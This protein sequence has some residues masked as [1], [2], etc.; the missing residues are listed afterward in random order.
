MFLSKLVS[1]LGT[2]GALPVATTA[3]VTAL[4]A[5]SPTVFATQ[6]TSAEICLEMLD[7]SGKA[8]T[9]ASEKLVQAMQDFGFR[10]Q[11]ALCDSTPNQSCVTSAF[12]L[13]SAFSLARE[14]AAK[15][16]LKQMNAGLALGGT[17]E[18]DI[19]AAYTSLTQAILSPS[20]GN[21]LTFANALFA[22]SD[23]KVLKTFQQVLKKFYAADAENL[24]FTH[25]PD[26]ATEHINRYVADATNKQIPELFERPL[27]ADTSTVLVNAGYFKGG[28]A[29]AFDPQNTVET[30]SFN[31]GKSQKLE[32][33]MMF[34]HGE[35]FGYLQGD[36][37]QMVSLSY[38]NGDFAMDLIVP[39]LT[40]RQDPVESL[41]RVQK[42]LTG[43][44]YRTWVGSLRPQELAQ[45]GLPRFEVEINLD[46]TQQFQRTFPL[47][48]DA[49]LADFSRLSR[50]R[51]FIALVKHAV[52]LQTNEIGSK[53]A[54]A[55]GIGGVRTISIPK[56][57][58]SVIADHPFIFVIRHVSTSVP[59]FNGTEFAPKAL[60]KPTAD[61]LKDAG[62]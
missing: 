3:F 34:H 50:E 6:R 55:T 35:V 49:K 45:L 13:M 46:M 26:M 31:Q 21:T 52:K 11:L 15:D 30:Y 44:N 60:P 36:G 62:L 9:P 5:Y 37:F 19:R 59:V 42:K 2:M 24:P 4:F 22:N 47:A 38:K 48:F 61:E 18:K 23:F 40:P 12:S 29:R 57:K 39:D 7:K 8:L 27:P 17:A 56:P 28:W 1:D 14:G 32:V 20:P 41:N 43:E 58:P 16:T 25:S 54:F 10:E 51:S 33:P 53:G